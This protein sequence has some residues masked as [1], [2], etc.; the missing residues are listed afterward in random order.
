MTFEP[1][2]TEIDLL[3]KN[4]VNCCYQVHKN[5]GP[6][7]LEKIYEACFCYELDKLN[8]PYQRQV[9]IPVIYDGKLLDEGL[10]VD[11]LVNNEVICE[12]KAVDSLLPIFEAQLLTYLKLS[13]KRLGYLV[14]FNV[15]NIGDGIKRFVL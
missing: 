12:F 13:K 14:N 3:G 10:R 9:I 8:I 2:P 15:K 7:L 5:L 6:G 11:V 1:I 4:I